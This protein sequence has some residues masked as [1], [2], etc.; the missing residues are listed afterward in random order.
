MV[1]VFMRGLAHLLVPM[2]LV[3]MAGA[4]IVV[5]ITVVLDLNDFFSDSG[6]EASTHD[7][8]T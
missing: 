1:D 6:D 5:I 8:L 4:A 7:G 3:G 2:F